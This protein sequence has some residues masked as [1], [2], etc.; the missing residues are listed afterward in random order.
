VPLA[1]IPSC[2]GAWTFSGGYT[3]YYVDRNLQILQNSFIGDGKRN[4]NVFQGAI[5][6]TF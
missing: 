3:W 5:G 2:Y 1:F 4:Q 6:L